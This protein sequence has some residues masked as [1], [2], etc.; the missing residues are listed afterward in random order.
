VACDVDEPERV[1]PRTPPEA[2]AVKPHIPIADLTEKE[3]SG[4]V[5]DLVR[6]L[7]WRR[8]HTFRS[9]R[10]PAGF[11]DEVLV[12]DRVV[13]LELKTEKGKLSDA[14]RDWLTAIIVAGDE[15][16]VAR[17]SQLEALV[18]C[19]SHNAVST[20]L[21]LATAVELGL[22]VDDPPAAA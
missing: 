16:Y 18:E 6:M 21:A 14:Q 15:A 19:L 12:R 17:P 11:P 22:T 7:G 9:D 13:F 3:W 1:A 10:S 5:A 20:P 4:Q 8:Y 2:A